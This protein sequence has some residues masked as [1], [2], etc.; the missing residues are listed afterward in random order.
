MAAPDQRPTLGFASA[1]ELEAWLAQHHASCDGIWLKIAKK[2]SGLRSV[3]LAEAVDLGLCFGWIDGQLRRIG[4]SHYA[5]RFTPRRPRSLW[6][7][8]NVEN[9]ERLTAAGR[10]RPA[11]L[12][13]VAAAK[14]DGRWEQAYGGAA[15]AT[16]P[17]DL[18]AILD[19]EP[20]TKSAWSALTASER[21]AVIYQ[22]QTA[23]RPE[24]RERRLQRALERLRSA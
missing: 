13:Q 4:E 7:K 2:N 8:R 3:T 6:S 21:Y 14:A 24:T 16:A 18:Q 1:L 5:I 10:M 19:A 22:L 23:R 9:V 17:D 15:G 12:A 20:A 11:G